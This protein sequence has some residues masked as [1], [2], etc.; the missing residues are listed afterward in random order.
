MRIAQVSPLYESVPPEQYGGTER[1][2]SY[3]TEELV[4]LGHEVTL[5][6]SGDSKTKARLIA[7][8]PRSLRTDSRVVDPLSHHFCMLEQ[9]FRRLDEFDVIHFHV[10]YLH[11][12]LSRRSSAT[13]MTT[14]HG[15]L[16]YPDLVPLF[17]EYAEMAVSSISDSQRGP[18]PWLNWQG[19]I[20]H[21][22]P[23][24]L[25]DFSPRP[26]K[27]L[28]FLGRVSPEK[29]PDRAIEISRRTGIPLKIAAKVDKVD[30]EY[31]ETVIKPLL[32]TSPTVEFIGEIGDSYKGQFLGEALALLFPINW[33]EPF[34]L[35]MI[36]A[37]ACGTPVIAFRRGSV[38]EVMEQGESGFI[39][40]DVEGAV[41][42]LAGIESFDRR[43]C[44]ARF[45]ARFTAQRM[46]EEYLQC[47]G[48]LIER[49]RL[50]SEPMPLYR[51]K[52]GRHYTIEGPVLRP[53]DLVAS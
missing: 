38:P 46:A 9:V 25:F 22:L 23:T 3:L 5:F 50:A 42:C 53:G 16:D 41:A 13:Q 27:Y 29:G 47:Y 33:P 48:S 39:V 24:R 4:A 1:I 2:A 52:R 49:N 19:T 21:G 10:D 30:K 34:G 15:R 36:E 14:L 6:A 28:A 31:F 43:K 37:M 40:E 45:D 8:Y 20:Y 32:D 7:P 12:P 51:G 18:L 11:F 17:K 26:G 44:R 35:V